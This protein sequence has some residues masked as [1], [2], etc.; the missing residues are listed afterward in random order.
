[1]VV[2]VGWGLNKDM[3]LNFEIFN[4]VCLLLSVLV[5]GSFLRDQKSTYLEG[6]LLVMVYVIIAV[7]SWFYPNPHDV[8]TNT[9]IGHGHA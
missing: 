2:I 6:G 8:A 7:T 3:S 1:M 4:V 9:Q 5:V